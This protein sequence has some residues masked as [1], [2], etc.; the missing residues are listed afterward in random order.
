MGLLLFIVVLILLGLLWSILYKLFFPILLLGLAY[1]LLEAYKN[2][3]VKKFRDIPYII[4]P[5]RD[6]F[7]DA[8]LSNESDEQA[9]HTCVFD[10]GRV[11]GAF[12]TFRGVTLTEN[13]RKIREGEIERNDEARK[14]A[15]VPG[16]DAV[17]GELTKVDGKPYFHYHRTH[18]MPFRFCLN[19]GEYSNVMFT[20]TSR[21]NAGHIPEIGVIPT[22]D[23]H[24]ANVESI[25]EDV[26]KDPYYFNDIEKGSYMAYHL[27]YSLDDFERVADALVYDTAESYRHMFKYG[28]ECLYESS[29][30]I[31]TH[32]RVRFVDTTTHRVLFSA[33]LRNTL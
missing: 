7:H 14:S 19:D 9:V 8:F 26:K 28:V 31:P 5:T 24:S 17:K 20:G 25:I 4:H 16:M 3:K 33:V 27:G 18:L 2:R 11:V 29:G 21:L 6:N 23:E 13:K 15:F 10:K 1:F 30:I 22:N 32:V 12:V